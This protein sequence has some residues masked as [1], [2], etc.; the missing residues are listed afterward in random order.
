MGYKTISDSISFND[1]FDKGLLPFNNKSLFFN[2]NL[3]KLIQ[4]YP[5]L[6]SWLLEDSEPEDDDKKT[7]IEWM[8]NTYGAGFNFTENAIDPDFNA[9]IQES[10]NNPSHQFDVTVNTQLNTD[11]VQKFLL[12]NG[13]LKQNE[14]LQMFDSARKNYDFVRATND[15]LNQQNQSLT[16]QRNNLADQIDQIARQNPTRAFSDQQIAHIQK[17]NQDFE[18]LIQGFQKYNYIPQGSFM[19]NVVRIKAIIDNQDIPVHAINSA[20]TQELQARTSEN[21]TFWNQ[22]NQNWN[23]RENLEKHLVT[24][25][26]VFKW[27]D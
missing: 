5:L 24:S 1:R 16:A 15:Q 9:A 18:K 22:P 2:G 23:S 17:Q 19:A 12:D 3:M 25:D 13:F 4:K 26:P 20:W 14:T 11:N 21:Q 10:L 8:L 7:R 6:W 27:N